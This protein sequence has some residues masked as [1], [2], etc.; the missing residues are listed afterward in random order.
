MDSILDPS[1]EDIS[2]MK[3]S[4]IGW[5]EAVL[6]MLGYIVEED[7]GPTLLVYPREKDYKNILADRLRPMILASPTLVRHLKNGEKSI[8]N[9]GVEFDRMKLH[10]GSA[11]SPASLSAH[12]I[13][14]VLC[15]EIDK[16]AAF[17]G[18]EADPMSLAFERTKNFWN[19]RKLKGSTPTTRRGYITQEYENSDQ[20]KF[21]LPCPECGEYQTLLFPRVKFG[22]ERN[23]DK[24]LTERLAWYEC[25]ACEYAWTDADKIRAL[26]RGVW[27][28]QGAE[29]DRDGTI[30]NM[31]PPS[32]HRGYW[33]N[34]LYSPWVTFSEAA[35]EFL[36]SKDAVRLLMNFVN[37]WLAEAWEEKTRE[38]DPAVVSARTSN[39]MEGTVPA[40]AIV[41]TAGADVQKDRI[42]YLIRAWGY[43]EESWLVRK[44]FVERWEEFVQIVWQT[45]YPREGAKEG[46]DQN[47]EVRLACVDSGYRTDEV[48]T[49]C[50]HWGNRAR[51]TK[52]RGAGELLGIP[53]KVSY[54]DRNPQTG[55]PDRTGLALWH[56]DVSYYKDKLNRFINA[57]PSD[58]FRFNIYTGIDEEYV[59]Q[60]CAERKILVRDKRSGR[61]RE[62]W[63]P[64][65]GYEKRNH[66]LDC[67][68][69]AAAA[70]DMLRISQLRPPENSGHYDPTRR[71]GQETGD[72]IGEHSDFIGG[73]GDFLD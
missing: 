37:S 64:K 30:H 9:E 62:V 56:L 28:P 19:R 18:R 22:D 27:L 65:I 57:E 66:Y 52:G 70:A 36:K 40:K 14:Y 7:P 46:E 53:Y 38:A 39:Y 29:I 42:Y 24:I 61:I 2:F 3:A 6:N 72:F 67:E 23:P 31:P 34:S 5:T 55:T 51:A 13:R 68:V 69:Y 49:V 32:I 20:R 16:Y 17:S 35:A 15:D 45:A 41:L 54:L 48:Y 47:L 4:Q 11:N 21:Y 26:R 43:Y 1:V 12:P 44:G 10:F 58:R 33:I 8:T 63:T 50:R 59:E 60:I 25:E 73:G 71:P